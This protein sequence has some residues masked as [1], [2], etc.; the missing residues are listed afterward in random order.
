[1]RVESMHRTILVALSA[2]SLLGCRGDG[3]GPTEIDVTGAYTLESVNGAALPWR[4]LSLGPARTEVTAGSLILREGTSCRVALTLLTTEDGVE[5]TV[6]N[7]LEC[8]Y[9]Y[10][11]G[12][13]TVSYPNGSVD[14]GLVTAS[15]VT[16]RSDNTIFVFRR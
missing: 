1:M 5:T 12:A 16:L 15:A 13:I 11:Y 10:S 4:L 7:S 9:T 14:T 6:D 2:L 3:L 8:E